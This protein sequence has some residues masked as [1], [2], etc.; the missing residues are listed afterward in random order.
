MGCI[1]V[2][3]SE[4]AAGHAAQ[5]VRGIL[6]LLDEVLDADGM[7]FAGRRLYPRTPEVGLEVDDAGLVAGTEALE[8]EFC[9]AQ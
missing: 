9:S 4:Q 3:E 7:R 5:V 6:A 8:K 2:A 1:R